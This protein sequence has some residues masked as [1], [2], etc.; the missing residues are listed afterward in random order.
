MRA[1]TR[2]VLDALPLT[3]ATPAEAAALT[4]GVSAG[5]VEQVL[6]SLAGEGTVAYREFDG[7]FRWLPDAERRKAR[8]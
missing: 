4:D 7:R 5:K 3:W 1:T 6:R 8:P 2:K